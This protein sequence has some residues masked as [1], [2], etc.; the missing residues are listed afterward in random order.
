[1]SGIF[2]YLI[3]TLI[4]AFAITLFSSSIAESG[5]EPWDDEC[6][7]NS[8]CNSSIYRY[9]CKKRNNTE[10]K[11]CETDCLGESCAVDSD[12]APNEHCGKDNECRSN[13]SE[14]SEGLAPWLTAVIVVGVIIIL[15]IPVP[16]VLCC[17]CCGAAAASRRNAKVVV[18][19][20]QPG[21]SEATNVSAPQSI[22]YLMNE[23]PIFHK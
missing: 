23:Q 11:T 6:N 10:Q 5:V 8:H 1:M 7:N 14:S 12:C 2:N 19:E 13:W 22:H 17:C 4:L 18:P 21:V 3:T 15:A 9:C 20:I 16:I